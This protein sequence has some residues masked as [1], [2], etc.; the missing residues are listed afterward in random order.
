MM[1]CQKHCTL[2]LLRFLQ[3]V[4]KGVTVLDCSGETARG[5]G[6]VSVRNAMRAQH[7]DAV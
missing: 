1:Q 3:S 7:N 5:S 6:N 2:H 4:A